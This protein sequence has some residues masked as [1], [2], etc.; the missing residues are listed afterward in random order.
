MGIVRT[1]VMLT[2]N[3]R[4]LNRKHQERRCQVVSK[5]KTE[6]ENTT[7]TTSTPFDRLKLSAQEAQ[8]ARSWSHVNSIPQPSEIIL[9]PP[10]HPPPPSNR[11]AVTPIERQLANEKRRL[12]SPPHEEKPSCGSTGPDNETFFSPVRL[13]SPSAILCPP[14]HPN[15]P[16]HRSPLDSSTRKKANE[17]RRKN[18]HDHRTDNSVDLIRNRNNNS[19]EMLLCKSELH[20]T[21]RVR[22]WDSMDQC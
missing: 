14:A 12:H 22:L 13:A 19:V 15:P 17:R 11:K 2:S 20:V 4:N 9:C 7:M 6:N 3:H 18:H 8:E 1:I 10:A 5:N 16:S 21:D